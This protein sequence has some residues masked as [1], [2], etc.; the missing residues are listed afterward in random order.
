MAESMQSLDQLSTLKPETPEAPKYDATRR[1]ECG[2][3]GTLP[4][5]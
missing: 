4:T 3:K 1:R 5:A 2:P